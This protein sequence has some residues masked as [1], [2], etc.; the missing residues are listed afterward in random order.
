MKTRLWRLLALPQFTNEENHDE[1][2]VHFLERIRSFTHDGVSGS[3]RRGALTKLDIIDDLR[4]ESG[5]FC[6]QLVCPRQ[7]AGN[8]IGPRLVGDDGCYN[9]GLRISGRYGDARNESLTRILNESGNRRIT[10]L[11]RCL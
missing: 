2:S 5:Q 10:A 11:R 6:A 8:V 4:F 3:S 7:K 9:S 1:I